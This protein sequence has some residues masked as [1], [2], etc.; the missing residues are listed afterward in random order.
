MAGDSDR[1]EL[2]LAP[3]FFL[4]LAVMSVSFY[5]LSRTEAGATLQTD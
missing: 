1:V 4:F 2:I 3:F 5:I